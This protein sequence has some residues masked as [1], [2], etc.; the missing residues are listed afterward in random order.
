MSTQPESDDPEQCFV[1][2][3][4]SGLY[5]SVYDQISKMDN[6]LGNIEYIGTRRRAPDI[7][8]VVDWSKNIVF[9]DGPGKDASEYRAAIIG[10]IAHPSLGTTISAKGNHYDGRDGE[11]FKPIDDKSKVKDVI[12]LR[13]P[14]MCPLDF[15]CFWD[16]QSTILQDIENT[17]IAT[18]QAAGWN[19]SFRS[20]LRSTT[21][22]NPRKDLITIVTERKYGVPAAAGAPRIA[23]PETPQKVERVKR[24]FVNADNADSDSESAG[25]SANPAAPSVRG[26]AEVEI[27]SEDQIKLGAFYDPRL[28]EDFG[29]PP[30]F[31]F[32]NGMLKQLDI[33]DSQNKL[34][35]PW[36]NYGALRPGSLILAIISIH[37]Y[38][39]KSE[40]ND[41][42]RDRKFFQL[43]AHSIRVLDESDFPGEKCLPPV[44]RTMEDG[45]SAGPSTPST[46]KTGGGGVNIN[47]FTFTPRSSPKKP[48]SGN[49]ADEDDAMD[50]GAGGSGGSPHKRARKNPGRKP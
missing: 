34:I 46:P 32:V 11:P 21:T 27:P 28:L 24:K 45:P 23:A 49:G 36:N 4:E 39:F 25:G 7:F 40:G 20:C 38:T 18:D 14:T 17:E 3:L 31:R 5:A 8:R 2:R 50:G 9:K 19:P 12:V 10:E 6:T 47:N 41:G 30:Y 42:D 43:N 22:Q 1:E 35:A 13:A 16:N 15:Q 44:P 26:K 37:M 33:R 48:A 29:G